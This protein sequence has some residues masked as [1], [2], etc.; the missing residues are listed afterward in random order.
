MALLPGISRSGSTLAAARLLGWE[1]Q[2]AARFSFLLAIPTIFGGSILE[3]LKL[4]N[5]A[6][7]PW[8][9]CLIG[10]SAS[11]AVGLGSLRLLFWILDRGTLRPF[12]WYCLAVGALSLL[13]M[14]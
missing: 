8:D 9:L 12:A 14:L 6:S 4:P 11:F 10:F 1:W 7:I 5:G 3:T 2:A 13:L